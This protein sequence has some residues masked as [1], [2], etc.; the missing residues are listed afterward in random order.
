VR[1]I[2]VQTGLEPDSVLGGNITDR[3]FLTRLADRGVEVHVLAE[4]GFPILSHPGLIPHHWPRRTPRKVPYA[5]NLDVAIGLRRLLQSLGGAD[6]VRFNHPYAVGV[7]AALANDGARLWGS[8][9]HCEDW[10]V[11]KLLDAWLPKRCDLVT[12][13]SEDTR[14]DVVARCPESDH[15]DNVVI[16]MGIDLARIDRVQTGRDALR[17][18]LG[19][20]DDEVL[21]LFA[22]VAIARKGISEA[23]DA[24]RSLGEEGKRARLLFLSKPVDPVEAGRISDL[25]SSDRRVAHLPAVPYEEMPDYY[26][27][28]DVFFFPTRREGFG[29]VVAEAMA[30]GL[31][32]VTTRAR[33]VREVVVE[34]ET[35]LQADVQDRVGLARALGRAIAD[36]ALRERLGKAGR[37]RVER[38]FS[39]GPILD[40]LMAKLSEPPLP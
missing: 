3:E 12:C 19:I 23:V 18:R 38:V 6:W 39:W 29:I 37:A 8:Y 10:R 25:V 36:P 17:K 32:V 1:L 16:P 20:A 13:L 31:P 7:G 21:V 22:G 26:R 5:S 24:W 4:E 9:L 2:A 30:C 15:D 34:G 33:G 40:R 14:R 35:A 11:W 28:A 27:A